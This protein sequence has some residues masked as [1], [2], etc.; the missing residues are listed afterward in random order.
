MNA[1]TLENQLCV[2]PR[3]GLAASL[4]WCTSSLYTPLPGPTRSV[5]SVDSVCCNQ[6]WSKSILFIGHAL[7]LYAIHRQAGRTLNINKCQTCHTDMRKRD[8][9]RER[10]EQGY[11]WKF[12]YEKDK[13]C[14][15]TIFLKSFFWQ[16]V[17]PS[18][19]L[20][21]KLNKIKFRIRVTLNLTLAPKNIDINPDPYIFE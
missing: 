10:D 20:L 12:Y 15:L 21:Y 13:K 7:Y 8:E 4:I 18:F 19:L 17:L 9:E 5:G 6:I 14:K 16:S 1:G 3:T 2:Q 11:V